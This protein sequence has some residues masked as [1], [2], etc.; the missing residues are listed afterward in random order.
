MGP[1]A[2]CGFPSTPR[3]SRG[4]VHPYPCAVA[5]PNPPQTRAQPHTVLSVHRG[6]ARTRHVHTSTDVARTSA[7]TGGSTQRIPSSSPERVGQCARPGVDDVDGWRVVS[8]GRHSRRRYRSRSRRPVSCRVV[9]V[10]PNKKAQRD[11]LKNPERTYLTAGWWVHHIPSHP[12]SRLV[13]AGDDGV[14]IQ[15]LRIVQSL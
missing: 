11:S 4:G 2:P 10:M 8:W 9:V 7:M 14:V 6:E 1:D 5:L 13:T 12:P 3:S 15:V